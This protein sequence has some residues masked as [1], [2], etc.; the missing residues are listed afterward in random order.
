[1]LE[2]IKTLIQTI[3]S[4][5]TVIAVVSPFLLPKLRRYIATLLTKDVVDEQK[6]TN[7]RL[8]RLNTTMKK[9]HIEAMHFIGENTV[10]IS[11]HVNDKVVH[12]EKGSG[13][14]G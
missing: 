8:A 3:A 1:M 2:E 5:V 4:A 7:T 11:A 12:G 9:N 10:A 6:K 14:S 13:V